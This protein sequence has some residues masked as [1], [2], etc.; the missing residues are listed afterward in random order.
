M[1][2]KR[3][4]IQVLLGCII[5][6]VLAGCWD[7]RRIDQTAMVMGIGIDP[8]GKLGYEVTFQIPSMPSVLTGAGQESSGGSAPA[9][10]IN[11]TVDA[12]SLGNAVST[13]QEHLDRNL[14]FG[15]LQSIIINKNLNQIQTRAALTELLRNSRIPNTA[16]LFLTKNTALSVL[17]SKEITDEPVSI[18]LRDSVRNLKTSGFEQPIPLW[19]YFRNTFGFGITPVV[20]RVYSDPEGKLIFDGLSVYENFKW[21]GD[22]SR[23]EAR[24]YNWAIGR[25]KNMQLM[26]QDAENPIVFDISRAKSHL[27]WKKENG[28]YQLYV[29]VTA[30]GLLIQDP[31]KGAQVVSHKQMMYMEHRAEE[32]IAQEITSAFQEFQDWGTDPYGFGRTIL[33]EDPHQ[34][35]RDQLSKNWIEYYKDSKLHV[36]VQMTVR[37]KG[38]LL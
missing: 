20:P 34:F 22:L 23:K 26:V 35:Q 19:V 3:L 29:N 27:G 11:I 7:Y 31:S 36:N 21:K 1:T 10:T 38:E 2:V 13:A 28:Q 24:G 12:E 33:I 30:E 17:A 6:P 32:E 4:I 8:K 25:V 18:F 14:F 9:P 37:G 15:N 16:S 5:L